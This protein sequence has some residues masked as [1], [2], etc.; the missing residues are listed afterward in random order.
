MQAYELMYILEPELTPEELEQ[1]RQAHQE[2]LTNSGA[3]DIE[4]TDFGR[5]KLAYEI[6]HKQ[7]GIYT[8]F[9]FN[10]EPAVAHQIKEKFSTLPKVLRHL[11][12]KVED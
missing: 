12:L 8:I 9:N 2:F 5:R 7:E 6:A 10:A 3:A 11:F 4:L 1:E